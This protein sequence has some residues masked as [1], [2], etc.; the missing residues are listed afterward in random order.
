MFVVGLLLYLGETVFFKCSG[1]GTFTVKVQ[2]PYTDLV[3]EVPDC[4]KNDT[5]GAFVGRVENGFLEKGGTKEMLDRGYRLERNFACFYDSKSTNEKEKSKTLE[6]FN[7]VNSVYVLMNL[8]SPKETK[9]PQSNENKK[10]QN[11]EDPNNGQPLYP[12]HTEPQKTFD[13][14]TDPYKKATSMPKCIQCCLKIC[15]C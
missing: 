3:I 8:E 6:D 7:I 15:E 4:K 13:A 14:L 11:L 9:S 5:L 10:T 1:E 12:L 2:N